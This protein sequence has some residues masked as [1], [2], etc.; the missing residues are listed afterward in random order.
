VS[1]ASQA[2]KQQLLDALSMSKRARYYYFGGRLQFGDWKIE[3]EKTNYGIL[4]SSDPRN[5]AHYIAVSRRFD[6]FILTYHHEWSM[7]DINNLGF[8]SDI[9]HP[10]L[11]QIGTQVYQ[12]LATPNRF[13]MDVLTLR[14]DLQ[15]GVSFKIDYMQG[16]DRQPQVDEFRGFSFGVDFVF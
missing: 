1:G 7:Q 3:G 4:K 12:Q 13:S 16:R 8:L 11:R 10:V 6:P 15:P 5:T 2:E 9:T 14:Y